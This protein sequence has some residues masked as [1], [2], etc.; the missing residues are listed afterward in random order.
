MTPGRVGGCA[1][2]RWRSS[3]GKA[4]RSQVW[5]SLVEVK[6]VK[7][8]DGFLQSASIF[9]AEPRISS[10]P[11]SLPAAHSCLFFF[12]AARGILVPWPGIEPVPSAL[13]GRVL[14]TPLSCT[15]CLL[16]SQG[17]Y[18]DGSSSPI[19][20]SLVPLHRA[21]ASK[22]PR[23]L[24][25]MWLLC[26]SPLKDLQGVPLATQYRP[27]SLVG[28]SRSFHSLALVLIYPVF[29]TALHTHSSLQP[30]RTTSCPVC[31]WPSPWTC[32]HCRHLFKNI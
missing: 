27:R 15:W 20:S 22:H 25:S 31:T 11:C 3:I 14:A 29:L 24:L 30:H 2:S 13:E 8:G 12:T 9:K 1:G 4:T 7:T 19:V 26:S 32:S 28:H 6:G 23:E 5:R 17:H 10:T 21:S 16:R 18:Q